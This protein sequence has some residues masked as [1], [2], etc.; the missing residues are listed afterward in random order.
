MEGTLPF[1]QAAL[2]SKQHS[3]HFPD[4]PICYWTVINCCLMLQCRILFCYQNIEPI[5]SGVML[6]VFEIHGGPPG[7][8]SHGCCDWESTCHS[9]S[10]GVWEERISPWR[11]IKCH[12]SDME[13]HSI[14]CYNIQMLLI[15]L[16][17][18]TDTSFLLIFLIKS[19][20]AVSVD[21]IGLLVQSKYVLHIAETWETV[22]KWA[23]QRWVSREVAWDSAT[24]PERGCVWLFVV[25]HWNGVQQKL[26]ISKWLLSEERTEKQYG[27]GFSILALPRMKLAQP[28]AESA[29]RHVAHLWCHSVF[30]AAPQGR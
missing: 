22:V 8:G 16:T 14:H 15:V 20:L 26:L 9:V 10:H 23:M 5:N 7:C 4:R 18:Q 13:L 17:L 29:C 6:C 21:F 28:T 1:C 24:A 12:Y 3:E 11:W 2:Y 30:I 25:V 27:L 19:A